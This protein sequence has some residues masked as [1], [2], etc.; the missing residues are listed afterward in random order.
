[1]Y[2][3][4]LVPPSAEAC[5]V[6]VCERGPLK[7]WPMNPIGTGPRWDQNGCTIS[8]SKLFDKRAGVFLMCFWCLFV[9]ELHFDVGHCAS[10]HFVRFVSLPTEGWFFYVLRF[11]CN[12]SRETSLNERIRTIPKCCQSSPDSNTC[13]FRGT[14]SVPV[15]VKTSAAVAMSKLVHVSRDC[16]AYA[17]IFHSHQPLAEHAVSGRILYTSNS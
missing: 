16:I 5:W 10:G 4:Q 2:Q 8:A 1:M 6:L 14:F 12:M 3:H 9:L 11:V 7:L 13:P 17:S 15:L